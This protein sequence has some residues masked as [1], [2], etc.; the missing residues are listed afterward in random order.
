MRTRA[1][2]RRGG[3]SRSIPCAESRW[4]LKIFPQKPGGK[5]PS[6][7]GGGL[8]QNS[9]G[10]LVRDD[11]PPPTMSALTAVALPRASTSH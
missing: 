6:Y 10:F 4:Q 1:P 8:H 9:A 3:A 7:L 2:W 5:F 11:L